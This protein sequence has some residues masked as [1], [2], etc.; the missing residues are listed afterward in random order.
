[1][2][3]VK[4]VQEVMNERVNECLALAKDKFASAIRLIYAGTDARR[5]VHLGSSVFLKIDDVQY[6][7]TAA[8]VIDYNRQ[9][10]TLYRRGDSP[11]GNRS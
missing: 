7:L 9:S 3:L 6:L 4:T 8:H 10:P 2:A 1:M 5:P 11:Y